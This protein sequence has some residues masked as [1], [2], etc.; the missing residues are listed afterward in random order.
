MPQNV[1]A[2]PAASIARKVLSTAFF[3]V[4]GVA[5]LGLLVVICGSLLTTVR[6]YFW[7]ATPCTIVE[8]RR[9]EQ[10]PEN[11]DRRE[12]VIRYRYRVEGR[13][14]TSEQLTVGMKE[15]LSS[16]KIERLLSRYPVGANAQCYVDKKNPSQAV[17]QR[18]TLLIA[19][20]LLFPLIFISVGVFGIISVW[21]TNGLS[22]LITLRRS[23]SR[24]LGKIAP[25][26]FFG[27]FALV[28]GVLLYFVTVRPLLLFL[29]ARTWPETPCEIVS[30]SVGSHRSS[31]KNSSTTYS[32]DIVYRYKVGG[33]EYRSERY[34]LMG[35]SSS[36][37]SGKLE[38]VG[39]YPAGTKTI[40][41]VSPT[42]PTE[43]LL[44]RGLSPFML[45]GL[46]P[47]LFF[48]VGVG[49][50]LGTIRSALKAS[51]SVAMP[52]VPSLPV[53][54]SLPTSSAIAGPTVLKPSISP[55]GK[56]IGAVLVAAI[57]NG[58][59][60]VFVV[61]AVKSWMQKN[62]DIFLSLF[63]IPFVLIGLGLLGLCAA[64]F[65]NLFNPRVALVVSSQSVPLGGTL[66]LRW[67]FRGA[68]SRIQRLRIVLEGR[69]EARY[70]RGTS[71]STDRAAFAQ[72]PII[73]TGE[74]LRIREGQAQLTIPDRLMH[75]WDGGNNKIVWELQVRGEIP[76]YPDVNEDF[77]FTILPK[78][79]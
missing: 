44:N 54:P 37:R 2:A 43:A 57:W 60:S 45:I 26:L 32:I 55:V 61:M 67:N 35:G 74:P 31:G 17:L 7:E 10:G 48:L 20:V 15:S 39:R 30:S 78:L 59:T 13:I 27:L 11:S 70:R 58:I 16:Q 56:F 53:Q 28:G 73:D 34:E 66:D 1:T 14:L 21:R 40:C 77:A 62:P 24:S 18:G 6:S 29:D 75:T 41:Y 3:G 8:S 4:F 47:A 65:L 5:G 72:L 23:Q 51:G 33:R 22:G 68:V 71:T 36:G 42:D 19:L 46:I 64:M 52:G 25:L 12:F 9:I 69:E 38:V 63:I 49:G 50:I 79:R 76:N